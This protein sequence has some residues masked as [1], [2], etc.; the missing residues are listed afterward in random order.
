MACRGEGEEVTCR[1]IGC[2]SFSID[3]C[4]S[5]VIYI[6]NNVRFVIFFFLEKGDRLS[7]LAASERC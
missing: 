1:A 6:N 5:D 7:A 4:E 3:E 2:R